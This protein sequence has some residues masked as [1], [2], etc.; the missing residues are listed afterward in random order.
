MGL[1]DRFCRKGGER[2]DSTMKLRFW[3]RQ[4]VKFTE[5][6]KIERGIDLV[7]RMGR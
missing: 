1:A 6:E 7:G 5:M 2:V 3:P 4:L